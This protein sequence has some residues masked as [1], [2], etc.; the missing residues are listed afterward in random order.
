MPKLMS[1]V[2]G[3]T[4]SIVMDDGDP[5]W[6]S[7]M[8]S[9]EFQN[10]LVKRSKIGLSGEKLYHADKP[11]CANILWGNLKKKFP[12]DLT[13][14]GMQDIFLKV[15]VNAVLHCATTDEVRRLLND[16]DSICSRKG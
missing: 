11:G 7:L 8:G 14:P 12:E 2:D 4:A 10:V 5:C 15:V 1:F 13:P 9:S 3:K 6:V 16:A